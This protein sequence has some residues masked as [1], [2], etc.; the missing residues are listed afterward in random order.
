MERT[1][2]FIT[3]DV[4]FSESSEYWFLFR[5]IVWSLI[6]LL[7]NRSCSLIKLLKTNF[8]W[9]FFYW[10][11]TDYFHFFIELSKIQINLKFDMY[12][13]FVQLIF[14]VSWIRLKRSLFPHLISFSH[15]RQCNVNR[16]EG[17]YSIKIVPPSRALWS[18]KD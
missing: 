11:V 15:K 2:V 10:D 1:S 18:I 4:S 7:S 9:I 6:K 13:L 14:L 5:C 17:V 12:M 3:N 16:F 8:L